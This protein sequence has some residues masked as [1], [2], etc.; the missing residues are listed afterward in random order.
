[1]CLLI[2]ISVSLI[3]HRLFVGLGIDEWIAPK[4]IVYASL[5]VLTASLFWL[6]TSK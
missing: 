2:G 3:A 1:L 5:A 6:L 4:V